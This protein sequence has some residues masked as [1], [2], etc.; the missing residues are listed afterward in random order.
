MNIDR[1]K[2]GHSSKREELLVEPHEQLVQWRHL[3]F[4]AQLQRVDAP[5][6]AHHE[7]IARVHV[8]REARAHSDAAR[9]SIRASST[10]GASAHNPPCCIYFHVYLYIKLKFSTQCGLIYNT[11][12]KSRTISVC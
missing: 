3:C 11:N 5:A 4:N 12:L 8:G 10:G 7:R 6:R 1:S 2:E 9:P